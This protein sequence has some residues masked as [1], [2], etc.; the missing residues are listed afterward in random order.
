MLFNQMSKVFWSCV[1]GGN[2]LHA[3]I[4]PNDDQAMLVTSSMPSHLELVSLIIFL[5]PL[6]NGANIY[7]FITIYQDYL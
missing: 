6:D 4:V 5:P 2:G 7:T 1:R 3:I